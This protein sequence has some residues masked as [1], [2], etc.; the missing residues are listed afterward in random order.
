MTPRRL[1]TAEEV[2]ERKQA[3]KNKRKQAE[4]AAKAAGELK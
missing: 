1:E 3:E 2:A 4:K